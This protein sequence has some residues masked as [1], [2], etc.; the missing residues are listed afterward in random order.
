MA[1]FINSFW[2]ALKNFADNFNRTTSGN[3]GTSSG[4]QLWTALRG[5]WFANGTQ[6]QSND[7][8]ATYPIASYDIGSANTLSRIDSGPGTGVAFWVTDANSWWAAYPFYSSTAVCDQNLVSGGSNPPSGSCCSGVS[9]SSSS[10]CSGGFVSNTSNPPGSCCSSVF[11]YAGYTYSPTVSTTGG[12]YYGPASS[13]TKPVN[14][15]GTNQCSTALST[16]CGGSGQCFDTYS[17]SYVCCSPYTITTYSCYTPVTTVY[18]CPS[19]GT[20]N[21]GTGLCEVPT[22]YGCYTSFVT[23]T[24]YSCYTGTTTTY[25]SSIRI[26]SSVSG[27]VAVDSTTSLGTSTSSNPAIASIQVTTSG[28]TITARGYSS[29]GQTTQLGSTI[30][31]TPS[32]PT[33]GTSI[34]IIKAP[35]DIGQSSTVDNYSVD[36]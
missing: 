29:A 25:D 4:G 20:Y 22:T 3:L 32:S 6:G 11:T 30:T 10:S 19:G 18:T 31:R 8:A 23:T 17:A 7:N 21:S 33:T 12:N 13:Y 26:V 9:S 16:L 2:F 5:T 1:S 27:T 36:V 24:T 28:N 34:G 14:L 35:S 15:R